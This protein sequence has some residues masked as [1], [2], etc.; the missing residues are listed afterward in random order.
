MF[1]VDSA[2]NHVLTLDIF[3][4]KRMLDFDVKLG[5]HGDGYLTILGSGSTYGDQ[6]MKR[7]YFYDITGRKVFSAFTGGIDVNFKHILEI[8]GSIYCIGSTDE[9]TAVF[10]KIAFPQPINKEIEIINTIENERIETILDARK[11]GDRLVLTSESNQYVLSKNTWERTKNQ[12]PGK[13]Q[14]QTEGF[15]G[16]PGIHFWVPS[17]RVQQQAVDV[18]LDGEMHTFLVWNNEIS[19][20]GGGPNES[21]IYDIQGN[22]VKFYPLPQPSYK[23]FR[24]FRPERVEDGYSE[25]YTTLETEIG[26]SQLDGGKII[27]GLG[28][29]D[30]EGTT[31]VGG[32]GSFD[33]HSKKFEVTYLKDIADSS[34]YSMLVEPDS[35]W[36]GLGGQPEG[37]VY[38]DGMAKIKRQDNS[39][40]LY[41]VPN[42]VNTIVRVGR[43]IYAGTSEG[44]VVIGEDGSIENIK[45]SINKE[46]G[47]S[48]V[49][50][51]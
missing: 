11:N 48:A 44:V 13:Y 15:A 51:K 34:V 27:F 23:L 16:L 7:K 43:A 19:A 33:L 29:Y 35:I 17:Y 14:Y 28:F 46:G 8:N 1:I 36:L 22:S 5:D 50:S 32:I 9:K 24:K 10:A 31:G 40:V 25:K 4:T 30:G 26:A 45:L 18:E 38:S 2:G 6:S 3:P 21:G 37:A 41:K 20:N 42:L 49:I 39:I 47:Y 12:A